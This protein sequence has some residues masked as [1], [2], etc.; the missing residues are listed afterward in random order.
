MRRL[1]IDEPGVAIQW[2][3]RIQMGA[4]FTFREPHVLAALALINVQ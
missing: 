3:G 2:M 1:R 4:V